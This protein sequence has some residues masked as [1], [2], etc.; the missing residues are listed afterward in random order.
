MNNQQNRKMSN[1]S[2]KPYILSTIILDT[3]HE[4]FQI[5]R[6][7]ER[8]KRSCIH[9]FVQNS[10]STILFLFFIISFFVFIEII[11]KVLRETQN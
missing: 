3:S 4:V 11:I 6:Y 5:E 1:D 9:I 7:H 2:I 8:R 10:V